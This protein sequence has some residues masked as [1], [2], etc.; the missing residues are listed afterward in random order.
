[1]ILQITP[2]QM[3]SIIQAAKQINNQTS[4]QEKSYIMEII[5]AVVGSIVT[6]AIIWGVQK[7]DK[8]LTEMDNKIAT[9]SKFTNEKEII[10][11]GIQERCQN[12]Q[13][14]V[15]QHGRDINKLKTKVFV[16]EDHLNMTH[17]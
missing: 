4:I 15:D 3:D 9:F 8:F 12:H 1:M 13:G 17:Q 6:F 14:T 5:V 16:I 2:D 7:F 10:I 11:T